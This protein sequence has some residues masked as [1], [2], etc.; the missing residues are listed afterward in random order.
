M[1]INWSLICFFLS[2]LTIVSCEQNNSNFFEGKHYDIIESRVYKK[3]KPL[4][5]YYFGKDG[6]LQYFYYKKIKNGL[7]AKEY[8]DI[9]SGEVIYRPVWSIKNDSV[10]NI[11]DFDY[12]FS[13]KDTFKTVFLQNLYEKDDYEIIRLSKVQ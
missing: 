1:R 9:F 3:N 13:T 10:F 8:I 2:L 6:K 5:G 12:K 7:E 11:M 4:N